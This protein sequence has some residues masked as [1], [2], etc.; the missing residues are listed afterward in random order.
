[1]H[2]IGHKLPNTLYLKILSTLIVT[3]IALIRSFLLS[4]F[5]LSSF[6]LLSQNPENDFGDWLMYFG[7]NKITETWSVHTELQVRMYKPTSTY[8][9]LLIR[10]GMNREISDNAM[11]TLGYGYIDTDPYNPE[12]GVFRKEHRIWEQFVL[13]NKISNLFFEHR[14]R[15]EQ[16]WEDVSETDIFSQRARYRLYMS[17]PLPTS[18]S[19]EKEWFLAVY[20]EIFLNLNENTFDQNRLYAAVGKKFSSQTSAQVGY[21][22]HRLGSLDLHRL[23]FALFINTDFSKKK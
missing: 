10:I 22:Y 9:Q 13:K 17:H 3:K 2:K 21:L 12:D 4:L 14:Y 5:L 11:A 16:R 15:L 23:Q 1:M 18:A 20:D 6:S 19:T 7:K 8:N